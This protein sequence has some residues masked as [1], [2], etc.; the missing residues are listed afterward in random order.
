MNI[1]IVGHIDHGKS[2]LIGRLLYDSGNLPESR[3]SEMQ[4]MC[5]EYKKKFEFSSFLDAFSDE[6]EEERTIGTTEAVFK[7][8]YLHTL[9]DVPGHLE[10]IEAMLT[11]ASHAEAAIIVVDVTKGLEEQTKRHLNLI[12]LLGISNIIAAVN[13]MDLVDYNIGA[14]NNISTQFE[15]YKVV[16]ISALTGDNIYTRSERFGTYKVTSLVE[17]L[18][19]WE[20]SK[21]SKPTPQRFLVQGVL[22]N[23][24]LGFGRLEKDRR[25][26]FMPSRLESMVLDVGDAGSV[27]LSGKLPKRGEVGFQDIT[28]KPA[29]KVW[30]KLFV[31]DG[32]LREWDRFE[33]R[34]GTASVEC[35]V[36]QVNKRISSET[37]LDIP[38]QFLKKHDM[39]IVV[40]SV[41]PIVVLEFEKDKELGRVT[42][43]KRGKN[44]AVG[45]VLG[46]E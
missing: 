44:V 17:L 18:D 38:G 21:I 10:F 16:P 29:S 7:G 9:I 27:T 3:L 11:G 22:S 4:A 31:L 39:G 25:V 1:V 14:F 2:T 24:V 36:L 6:V 46:Y 19:Y 35:G 40:L 26:K 34:C 12:K 15:T 20:D 13:K 23:K 45:V 37:G 43:S 33:F 28:P 41:E 8:K 42:L 5:E 32:Q 30:V